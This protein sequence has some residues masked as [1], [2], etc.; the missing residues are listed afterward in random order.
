MN[1][2]STRFELSARHKD[3]GDDLILFIHG[4]GCSK[5]SFDDAFGLTQFAGFQLMSIDLPG[6]G[7]SSKPTNFSYSMED[8]AEILKLVLDDV[9]AEKVHIVAH[10]MGGAVG[11]LLA[12][13]ILNTLASF[14]NIEGNLIA[15]DCGLISRKAASIPFS[16]F[17]DQMFD[18][19]RSKGPAPWRKL[20]MKSDAL[21]FYRSSVSLVQW[22]DNGMLLEKFRELKVSKAYV[23]GEQNSNMDILNQLEGIRIICIPNSGHFVMNDNPGEFYAGLQEVIGG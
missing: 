16:E 18:R 15:E 22:S 1:Y 23:Y 21:G 12:E 10:S 13:V 6:Y 17:R 19:V 11:L 14:T 3:S 4:L 2:R 20:S 8:Q 7:D 9:R 5:E